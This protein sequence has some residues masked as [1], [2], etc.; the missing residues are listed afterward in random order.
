M[1]LGKHHAQIYIQAKAARWQQAVYLPVSLD[2]P[3]LKTFWARYWLQTS[4]AV[5]I[6]LVS[7]IISSAQILKAIC[8]SDGQ[9]LLETGQWEQAAAQFVQCGNFRDAP[10]LVLESHYRYGEELQVAGIHVPYFRRQGRVFQISLEVV[11]DK[12]VFK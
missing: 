1:K 12:P 11:K 7:L 10:T 4:L 9:Q 3:W 5:V 6:L 8:Y 2:L